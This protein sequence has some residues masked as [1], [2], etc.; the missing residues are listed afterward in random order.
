M[1][2]MLGLGGVCVVAGLVAGCGGGSGSAASSTTT[3]NCTTSAE[4]SSSLVAKSAVAVVAAGDGLVAHAESMRRVASDAVSALQPRPAMAVRTLAISLGELSQARLAAVSTQTTTMGV[5]RQVGLGRSLIQT[6]SAS[7]T[8]AALDWQ[9]TASGG[10]VAAI[11]ISSDG[12]K[13]VRL[14]VR[15]TSL[16]ATATLRVYAQGAA[17]AYVLSAQD[18]LAAVQRNLDAGDTSDAAHMYWTPTIAGTEAT[19]EIELPAQ[20]P[21]DGVQIAIPRL[22]HLYVSPWAADDNL[23]RVSGIGAAGSCEVDVSCTSSYSSESNAVAKIAFVGSDGGAYLCS[24]ALV[25][26]TAGSGSPYFLSANH[27]V[28]QQ[29]VASTLESYWFYRSSACN[30][31]SLS[32]TS[33]TVIG[34]ATLLYASTGTDTSFMRL[35]NMPPTGAVYAG[36]SVSASPSLPAPT[37]GAAVAGLHH[38]AGDLQKISTGSIASFQNCTAI[39]TTTDTFSCSAS[40]ASAGSFLNV[41]YTS[42]ITESG[43][44]GSPL[45]QTSG[46]S[47]YLVGQLYGGTSSC[48][49]TSG[50]N[51]YGRFDTAYNAALSTWLNPVA[52]VSLS[53]SKLGNGT[54]SISSSPDGISCGT[55][56]TAPFATGGSVTLT[57][58]PATGSSFTGW[59]GACSGSSTCTLSMDAG[60]AATASFAVP[61]IAL[62]TALDDSLAWTTGGDVGFFGQTSVSNAGGSAAQSGK[63]SNNQRSTLSTSVTGPGSLKFDWKVSSESG[64]DIFSVAVDGVTQVSW[65]GERGWFTNTLAIS[66]GSHTVAWTYAKNASRSTGSDAG[67]V[68]NVVY[69]PTVVVT[70]PTTPV[71]TTTTT[72][73][74]TK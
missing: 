1:V 36:W 70:T 39:D 19:L 32:S 6:A 71:T 5:P 42:G 56:C 30:S 24:G 26:D 11:S 66:A 25:A 10:K 44:S 33:Q 54:G 48:T 37:V 17:N 13:G 63:I 65:S 21:T 73:T 12:A 41:L 53:V 69:T 45:F 50:A 15:V 31:G 34:G 62:A 7:G 46:S 18:V 28:S 58:T 4:D 38:P 16:P 29:S 67:W 3:T 23:G 8:A 27:C 40:S 61:D 35:G 57:A 2:R 51:V 14:G 60:K 9:A 59:G 22:A 64:G 55:A 49:A 74:C 52:S 72:T 43:S 68:D 47:H 20:T